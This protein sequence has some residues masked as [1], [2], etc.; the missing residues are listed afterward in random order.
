MQS[1]A[2]FFSKTKIKTTI[3]F[4][5]HAERN[6][7]SRTE[8]S[9]SSFSVFDSST[10]QTRSQVC[11]CFDGKKPENENIFSF[12][13]KSM[14][15]WSSISSISSNKSRQINVNIKPTGDQRRTLIYYT[16]STNYNRYCRRLLEIFFENYRSFSLPST[17]T[18]RIPSLNLALSV[19]DLR[20]DGETSSNDRT[21][22]S[23]RSSIRSQNLWTGSLP[24]LT[25]ENAIDLKAKE[26]VRSKNDPYGTFSEKLDSIGQKVGR[27]SLP[28][29]QQSQSSISAQVCRNETFFFSLS[30]IR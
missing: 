30:V 17:K 9:R 21:P 19:P 8:L 29:S 28:V 13:T 23:T 27:R 14:N 1:N 16:D 12:G 2:L 5:E 24:N 6:G 3:R 25:G 22:S 11:F 10:F 20:S 4:S 18:K 15:S 26:K 7:L